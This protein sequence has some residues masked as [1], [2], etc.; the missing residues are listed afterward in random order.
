[1]KII[2]IN[3]LCIFAVI[4][5]L[6]TI[7]SPPEYCQ[8]EN[9]PSGFN[10]Y[11]PDHSNGNCITHSEY[12][13]RLLS[14]NRFTVNNNNNYLFP[15][16]IWPIQNA[17]DNRLVLVNYVDDDPA[18]GIIK[19]YN[20]LP[21]SYDGHNG[22]DIT[23]LNFRDMD[24]GMKIYAAAPGIVWDVVYS[25]YD[26]NMGGPGLPP[27]NYVFIKHAD[28]T[29][30]YYFHVRKNSTTVSI[31]DNV[32]AGQV[33]ALA[34]SSGNSSDAHLHFEP[35]QFVSNQWQKRD[36]WHG[37]F[38]TAVTLWQ[39]QAPY[40]GDDGLKV[41]D[42]GVFTQL[43]C[44]G[45]INSIPS[46]LF[47]E[48]L[49]QPVNFG[50]YEPQIGVFMQIQSKAGEPYTL[51]VRKP[52]NTLWASTNGT[53]NKTQYGWYYWYWNFN[54]NPPVYGTWYVR[55]LKNNVELKRTNFQV[56][57]LSRYSPRF[58]PVAGKSFRRKNFIQ[59]DTLRVEKFGASLPITYTLL[60]PPSNVTLVNDSIVT[61]GTNWNQPNVSNYFRVEARM[62][63]I[64]SDMRDTFYYHMVDTTLNP[65]GLQNI[66][67]GIPAN[68]Q[69]SQNYPNPFNPVTNIK[70]AILR[71]GFVKLEI[72]DASGKTVQTLVNENLSAGNYK[73][74]FEGTGLAS[75]IYFYRIETAEFSDV[76][77]MVLVK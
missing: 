64:S 41:Y 17:I 66:Q 20:G 58:K 7:F 68:Y 76:K 55:V 75:G 62:G 69:L 10:I 21:H 33:I 56:A 14:L 34:G 13:N 5:S 6:L 39:N 67:S 47:K 31:G 15:L 54:I 38:N 9:T 74:G 2:S 65:T 19:D 23:L 48:R 77:K 22:T 27:A 24:E 28:N 49:T 43:S 32:T 29:F 40:V 70:F 37:T 12:N 36:P 4:Y 53:F 57:L 25:N 52:D 44:G 16:F 18:V 35:G 30:A 45:N 61:I 1:M 59:R 60:N 26:R 72:F 11:I 51:E 46:A 42:L 73:I 8:A 50:Y 71:T 3:K 63:N